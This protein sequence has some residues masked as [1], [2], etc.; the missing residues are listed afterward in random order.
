[1]SIQ[2]HLAFSLGRK[3]QGPN[4]KLAAEIANNH[5]EQQLKQLITF[6]DSKPHKELQKDCSLTIAWIA[7][8]NPSM[9]TPYTPYLIG[10][11]SDPINRVIWGSMMAL[12]EIA[13]LV[14]DPI[15]DALPAI[16]DA[17]DSGTVVTRDHGYRILIA[18]YQSEH[19]QEDALIFILEQLMKAPS[20]QLGQYAERLIEVVN[21][22]HV[23]RIIEVLEERRNDVTNEHHLKRLNKNLK[24][25]YK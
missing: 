11:L 3:D 1:M 7:E 20:N 16:I 21:K 18:L 19:Y 10:K 15:Y 8:L 6:F 4:K 24:R 5:D 17:M 2:D 25:L 13:P 9:V 14:L 23:N 12:S 22:S